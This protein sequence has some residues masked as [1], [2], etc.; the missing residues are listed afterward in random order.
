MM[1]GGGGRS[2]PEDTTR[3]MKDRVIIQRLLEY[4]IP[5]K[6]NFALTFVLMFLGIGLQLIQPFLFGQAFAIFEDANFEYSRLFNLL[7]IYAGTTV[8]SGFVIYNQQMII[9]RAGQSIIYDIREKTFNHLE[10]QSIRYLN[11]VPTGVLVTRIT[12]DTQTLSEM[13]TSVLVNM[14]RDIVTILGIIGAILGINY[15]N[16]GN[17]YLASIILSTIPVLLL[18]TYLFQKVNRKIYRQIRFH[19]SRVNAY[20][21]EHLAGMKIV[22]IFNQQTNKYNN[23]VAISNDLQKADMKQL[24]AFAIYRPTIYMIRIASFVLLFLIGGFEVLSGAL[25]VSL[26]ITYYTYLERLFEPI[27]GFAEQ[28]NVL[29]SALV[30]SERIFDILGTDERI[31]QPKDAVLVADF[32]GKIVFENVWFAYEKEDW[33]LQD[34]SFTVQ[35]GESVAFVGATGAGKTTILKLITRE[36]D[37]QKGKI[38]VDGVDVRRYDLTSLRRQFG[39]ML[40]DVFLF[41]GTIASNIRLRDAAIGQ[42][43]M[44]EA[45]DYVNAT[46]F[47]DRLPHKYEEQ[48]VERGVNYSQ[49]QRQLLSFART[50][51]HQPKAIILDEATANID[52]ETE[53]IIQESLKKIM[54]IGTTLIVA[55]RLSTIQHVDQIIV[56]SKGKI[57]EKGNHQQLLKE[58]GMYY[59]L[60]QIQFKEGP[61]KT[62]ALEAA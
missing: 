56:M 29:Q 44:E 23:F 61:A 27:Q 35:P 28:L 3:N 51:T 55:H 7:L 38:L 57:V 59:N 26:V 8:L 40:Q 18:F 4:A 16:T 21:S 17:V 50:L 31:D 24:L 11:S 6:W 36:Y 34:V 32:K 13:Y 12:N 5:Y 19:I 54:T 45:C 2:T 20:L 49:G 22:Q 14:T 1:R 10:D 39:V 46:H 52:T 62:L 33:I 41:T 37:I 30:A 48:V 25:A 53:Q 43:T 9:Q 60:Y 42:T 47:I 15:V 58:R